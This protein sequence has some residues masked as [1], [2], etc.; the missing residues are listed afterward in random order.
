[1]RLAATDRQEM[2]GE[3]MLTSTEKQICW[4][5]QED[6]LTGRKAVT[7]GVGTYLLL[8]VSLKRPMRGC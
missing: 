4:K 2:G 3:K 1:M 6:N 8:L 7:L 5:E